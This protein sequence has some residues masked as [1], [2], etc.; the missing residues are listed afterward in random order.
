MQADG[1]SDAT[2]AVRALRA[3]ASLKRSPGRCQRPVRCAM[4]V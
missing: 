1:L 3:S 4:A 2:K